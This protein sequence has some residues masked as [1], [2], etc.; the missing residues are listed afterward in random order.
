MILF[1]ISEPDSIDYLADWVE[2]YILLNEDFLSK[3]ALSSYVAQAKG[4]DPASILMDDVWVELESRASKYGLEPPFEL[5]GSSIVPMIKKEDCL[6]YTMCLLL[7]ILGNIE[8]TTTTGKLF[9]RVSSEA[10]KHYLDGE[11]L[12]YGH[13]SRQSVEDIAKLTNEKFNFAPASNFKDRGL[14]VV[15]WKSFS[16]GRGS[17]VVILFQCASG[18]NWRAKLSDLPIDAWKK[19]IAWACNPL[20]GFTLPRIVKDDLFKESC[21]ECGIL[22][23]RVRIYRN[24]YGKSVEPTLRE[25]ISD[26]CQDKIINYC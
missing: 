8:H 1:T 2:L 21:Y 12:V 6:E 23:D 4:E 13:P 17:Q 3:S 18:K 20:K 25:E 19:Y 15:L 7:S 10:L 5:E 9:E 16:D 14:D 11:V 26:W 22:F 24:I